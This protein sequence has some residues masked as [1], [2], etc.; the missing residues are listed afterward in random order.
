[1]WCWSRLSV[2]GHCVFFF[3]PPC[4]LRHIAH[5]HRASAWPRETRSSTRPH[6]RQRRLLAPPAAPCLHTTP[7]HTSPPP[8]PLPPKW[9]FP[10][11]RA[12]PPAAAWRPLAAAPRWSSGP[13]RR[14]TAPTTS[15][16]CARVAEG[17]GGRL[18]E[19]LGDW[20]RD[21]RWRW[22]PSSER[23]T[24]GPGEG[25]AFPSL[26]GCG[27]RTPLHVPRPLLT[28]SKL[29]HWWSWPPSGRNPQPPK[30]RL[31]TRLCPYPPA[32]R[33]SPAGPVALL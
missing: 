4:E 6:Q 17:R 8:P 18:R 14:L 9:P 12:P 2:C 27:P 23:G 28:R 25:T 15:A 5:S 13:R 24:P 29:G 19:I 33:P 20:V 3:R 21:G 22:G 1:M 16:W 26:A 30:S 7:H 11:P 31:C 10:R 32:V